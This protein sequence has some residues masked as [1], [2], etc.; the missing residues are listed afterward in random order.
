MRSMKSMTAAFALT[1]L[2]A[3][4]IAPVSAADTQDGPRAVIESSAQKMLRALDANREEYTRDPSKVRQLVD[5]ILLPNFDT[6]YAAKRILGR[7]H[8]T[9]ASAEQRT[10]FVKAFYQ[11][12]LG[13]YGDALIDFTADR[14]VVLPFRGDAKSSLAKVQTRVQRNDGTSVNVDYV[15]RRTAAGWKAWDVV[16]EG[17]SY[18]TSLH[19]DMG[20]EIRQ[21]GLEAV[22]KRLETSG[23]KPPAKQG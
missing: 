22:I 19:D 15:L 20:A 8:W 3:A 11:A 18:V 9:N 4:A 13:T 14:L 21:K 23:Y 6:E 10:R 16:I 7:E 1:W 12:L 17:I 2:V 5:E